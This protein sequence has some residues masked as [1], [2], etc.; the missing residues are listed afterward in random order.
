MQLHVRARD[1]ES[2]EGLLKRFKVG[3]ERDGVLREFR[4]HQTFMSKSQKARLKAKKAA[5]K[6]F[7][8]GSRWAA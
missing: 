1:G 7:S 2:F 5:R 8:R 6:R 4:K 3:V